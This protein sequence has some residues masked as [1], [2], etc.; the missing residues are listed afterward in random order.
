ML[1]PLS[2]ITQ[3]R[4]FQLTTK[5]RQSLVCP[6]I[7]ILTHNSYVAPPKGENVEVPFPDMAIVNSIMPEFILKL[8]RFI[9]C[10]RFWGR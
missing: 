10:H 9:G 3:K 7:R 2:D 1:R 6:S 4:H 5:Q 8:S